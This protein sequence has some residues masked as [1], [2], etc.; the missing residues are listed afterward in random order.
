LSYR[1]AL[2]YPLRADRRRASRLE[3]IRRDAADDCCDEQDYVDET[4][5]FS[6]NPYAQFFEEWMF[7]QIATLKNG[8]TQRF[9]LRKLLAA[10][11]LNMTSILAVLA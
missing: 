9:F 11:L 1:A 2:P 8:R 7:R 10:E 6:P 4:T 5:N 3:E